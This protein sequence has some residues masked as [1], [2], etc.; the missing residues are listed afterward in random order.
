MSGFKRLWASTF[1][2]PS[3]DSALV[4]SNIATPTVNHEKIALSYLA[5]DD[6]PNVMHRWLG[7]YTPD[8]LADMQEFDG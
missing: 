5:D 3:W 2:H 1:T 6:D 7:T 8:E 4:L